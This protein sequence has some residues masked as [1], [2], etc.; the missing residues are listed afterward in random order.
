MMEAAIRFV[1]G[2]KGWVEGKMGSEDQT[3]E[4]VLHKVLDDIRVSV[5]LLNSTIFDLAS[6]SNQDRVCLK[7]EKYLQDTQ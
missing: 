3:A 7:R 2:E 5:A 1:L 4:T 6:V